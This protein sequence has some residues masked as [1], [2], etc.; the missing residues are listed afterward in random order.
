MYTQ[1][2]MPP[3]SLKSMPSCATTQSKRLGPDIGELSQIC[4]FGGCLFKTKV[5]CCEVTSRTP[6][7]GGISVKCWSML[8]SV[9]LPSNLL[10]SRGRSPE[11]PL[12]S[13]AA[14]PGSGLR[15]RGTPLLRARSAC[16]A[17]RGPRSPLAWGL[18]S[19]AS[20][21]LS[22]PLMRGSCVPGRHG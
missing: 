12:T 17:R 3:P 6:A 22:C 1:S 20:C 7:C 19:R 10:Q 9:G 11:P 15:A 5:F 21:P 18:L 16:Q 2:P 8:C 14:R 4:L 13:A